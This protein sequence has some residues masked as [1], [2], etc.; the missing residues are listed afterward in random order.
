M[1]SELSGEFVTLLFTLRYEGH[2]PPPLNN[3]L[4]VKL[5]RANNMVQCM[6][7]HVVR[8]TY[9]GTFIFVLALVII[10]LFCWR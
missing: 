2:V 4:T 7:N 10:T 8:L 1:V 3:G 6:V 9:C 5:E